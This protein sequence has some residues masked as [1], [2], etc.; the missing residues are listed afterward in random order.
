MND[1][2]KQVSRT[3]HAAFH[4]QNTQ[5][6]PNIFGGYGADQF[7]SLLGQYIVKPTVNVNQGER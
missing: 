5:E 4:V 1:S 6:F 2:L 3:K 7:L